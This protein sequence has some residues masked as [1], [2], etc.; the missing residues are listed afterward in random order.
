MDDHFSVNLP[1]VH[2]PKAVIDGLMKEFKGRV[3][4]V[5][6]PEHVSG[7]K[8]EKDKSYLI[9]VLL[10]ATGQEKNEERAISKN[11]KRLLL[12]LHVKP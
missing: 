11:G 2:S 6:S 8:M 3:H 9:M 7:L 12:H 10:P 5:S 1:A 4:S